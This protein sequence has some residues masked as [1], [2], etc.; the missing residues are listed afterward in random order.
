M[1]RHCLVALEART[2]I[3]A[4]LEVVPGTGDNTVFDGATA[5]GIA[6][7]GAGV[8]DRKELPIVETEYGEPVVADAEK[9]ALPRLD[10]AG[11]ELAAQA[12]GRVPSQS[13]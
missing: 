11:R 1:G 2:V 9:L 5:Q 10:L 12:H 7:M 4:E 6:L 13:S 3:E 8:I